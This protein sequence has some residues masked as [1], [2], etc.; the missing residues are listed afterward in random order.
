VKTK[1]PCPDKDCKSINVRPVDGSD[2]EAPRWECQNCGKPRPDINK[3]IEMANRKAAKEADRAAKRKRNAEAASAKLVANSHTNGQ[4]PLRQPVERNP[5]VRPLP[6]KLEDQKEIEQASQDFAALYRRRE[7]TLEARRTKMAEFKDELTGIDERMAEL[8]T[9][10][11]DHLITRP[12]N[13][14]ERFY[15]ETQTVEV[16]RL[17]SGEIVETR[18]AN[19]RDA[20][21][22]LFDANGQ[23][24]A[25]S[26]SE[27]DDGDEDL[28]DED[29]GEGDEEGARA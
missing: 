10:V 21:D 29:E 12:V 7:A 28:G 23:P 4:V 15:V 8:A 13:C 18:A 22:E 16:V 17:D 9:T 6:C 27:D 19:G 26:G 14:I 2:P 25:P 5:H 24:K 1:T 20:Q 3:E 11:E